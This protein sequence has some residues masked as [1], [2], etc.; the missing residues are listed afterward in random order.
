MK[1][2]RTTSLLPFLLIPAL[3]LGGCMNKNAR[4]GS[5][6]VYEGAYQTASAKSS[7]Y[8]S[9]DSAPMALAYGDY[10]TE[11][12]FYEEDDMADVADYEMDSGS[13]ANFTLAAEPTADVASEDTTAFSSPKVDT[14]K[15]VYTGSLSVE[16][17]SFDDTL[18]T[19]RKNINDLGGFIEYESQN[20]NSF[21]WY[22]EGYAK[23]RATLSASIQARIPSA[24]FYEFL[25]GIESENAKVTS[26]SV[27][28]ENISRQYSET[29]TRI[30]SYEIQEE[31]LLDMMKEAKK[32]SDM[33]EIED[34]LSEVQSSLKQLR[35]S[36]ASM[37]TDVA[38]STVHISINE[39]GIYSAPE[40]TTFGERIQKAFDNG[41][42]NFQ[43][44]CEEFVLFLAE[45]F[46]AILV[47]LAILLLCFLILRAIIRRIR[48]KLQKKKEDGK[49]PIEPGLPKE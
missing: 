33:L 41:I 36:L 5:G 22:A 2:N 39:V 46:L 17:T 20:D 7:G 38:Y 15:L 30:E 34:R 27:N 28:V 40:A 19:L 1:A 16:T 14:Q 11:E 35:N 29:A 45:N 12:A 26:R 47:N 10:A 9:Y 18:N 24:R 13:T 32:V 8:V 49:D 21:G 42:E 4:S 3:L 48:R 6:S 43:E 37:D 25:D 31:R 23:S 44:G